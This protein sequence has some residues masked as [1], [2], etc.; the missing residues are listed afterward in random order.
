VVTGNRIGDDCA[1]QGECSR[2]VI[3]PATTPNAK[4]SIWGCIAGCEV[5]LCITHAI[6]M[7]WEG[8]EC[9]SSMLLITCVL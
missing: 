3:S 6:V 1:L 5:L 2:Q 8:G 9:H 4:A 7:F